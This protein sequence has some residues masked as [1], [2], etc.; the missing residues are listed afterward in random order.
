M[1]EIER[2]FLV[3]NEDYKLEAS[4][5][6]HIVQGYLNRDP[7]RTLRIR[8]DN[9]DAY[10][11]IKGKSNATGTTR[12]E[13]QKKIPIDEAKR[14]LELAEPGII[15]KVRYIIPVENNLVFEVDEFLG[16]H[17]GLTLAEIELE[18]EEQLF[19]KPKWLGKEVTGEKKYYNS[20]ISQPNK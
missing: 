8:I 12:F 1:K 16:E 17:E 19:T 2:K 3:N 13:W 4:E 11:T 10:I 6:H 18:D 5:I 9:A 20:Y 14:L 7:E 15:E